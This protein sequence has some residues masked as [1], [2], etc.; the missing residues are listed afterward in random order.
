MGMVISKKSLD[1]FMYS[2]RPNIDFALIL[3]KNSHSRN[4]RTDLKSAASRP[5]TMRVEEIRILILKLLKFGSVE[6]ILNIAGSGSNSL[7]GGEPVNISIRVTP[8]A[9]TSFSGPAAHPKNNTY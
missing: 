8:K 3:P 5:L 4:Q 6:A 9:Q 2:G 7:N 1:Y